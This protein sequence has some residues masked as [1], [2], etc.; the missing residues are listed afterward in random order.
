MPTLGEKIKQLRNNYKLTQEQLAEKLSVNRATL[1]SWEID[2]AIPDLETI[3]NITIFFNI[4]TD[5]L[6][7]INNKML[8]Q[9]NS[10]IDEHEK[11]LER[12]TPEQRRESL[13][14]MKYLLG[15]EEK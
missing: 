3:K 11:L 6:L 8:E 5:Y 2:R 1:A 9:I 14:Y 13:N 15:K 10:G 4:S 7:G 12:M